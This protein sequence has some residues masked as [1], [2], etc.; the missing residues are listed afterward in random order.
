[1]PMVPLL[2]LLLDG[3]RYSY[4][5]PVRPGAGREESVSTVRHALRP[6]AEW[7]GKTPDACWKRYKK[8]A[9]AQARYT[10]E[11]RMK[12]APDCGL[13]LTLI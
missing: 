10:G 12:D 6:V 9:K 5:K 13:C 2:P 7:V 4:T 1:M 8:L 3:A 11:F